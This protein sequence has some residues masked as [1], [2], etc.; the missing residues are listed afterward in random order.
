MLFV[1]LADVESIYNC[2]WVLQVNAWL[3]KSPKAMG[4][5]SEYCFSCLHRCSNSVEKQHVHI[6]SGTGL[7]PHQG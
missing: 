3:A 4:S 5:S 6:H 7:K 2:P 1:P